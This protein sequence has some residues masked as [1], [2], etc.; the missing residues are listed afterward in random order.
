MF[1]IVE[2]VFEGYIMLG[3]IVFE[4]LYGDYIGYYNE[5]DEFL[6][7]MVIYIMYCENLIYYSIYIGCLLDELVVF[8]VV[9][10]EVFV[11]I[12]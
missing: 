9:L 4:G 5:V 8:G 12:L 3:E 10:N 1:V 2:F 7:M 6:V 11:L